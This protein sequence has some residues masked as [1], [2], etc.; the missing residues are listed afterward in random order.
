[1]SGIFF[2]APLVKTASNGASWARVDAFFPELQV[3][4]NVLLSA[5]RTQTPERFSGFQ[6]SWAEA[7]IVTPE[8]PMTSV[9]FV[10][11]PT[12]RDNTVYLKT[13]R[14]T[15]WLQVSNG[16]SANLPTSASA[17]GII[18]DT[19]PAGA[20]ELKSAVRRLDLAVH[21]EDG[22]VVGTHH[23]LQLEGG[24]D[25]DE[26]ETRERALAEAHAVSER[27]QGSLRVTSF[28]YDEIPPNADF[29]V[30]MSTGRPKLIQNETRGPNASRS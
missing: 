11:I 24:P 29:K 3:F 20:F 16:G 15:F 9:G 2:T 5:Y 10:S 6:P 7:Y 21:D 19:T 13:D 8:T 18:Y 17:V 25:F 1:V 27:E 23:L 26:E 28:G 12:R 14:L 22:T 30:D 4:A